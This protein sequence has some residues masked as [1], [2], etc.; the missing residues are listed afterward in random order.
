MPKIYFYD[1]GLVS[2]LLGIRTADQIATHPLRGSL[3]ETF[4]IS[5]LIKSRMNKGEKPAFFFWRDSNGNEIDLIVEKGTNLM[6]IEIKSGRTITSE[7][8]S[9]LEKW[10]ALAGKKAVSPTLIYGG[11]ESYTQKGIKVVGWKDCDT[12]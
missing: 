1:V 12:L 10:R 4:I 5:E 3:F 7:A 11:E 2:W 6:P 8:F 9:G